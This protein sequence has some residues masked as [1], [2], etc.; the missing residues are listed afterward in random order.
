MTSPPDIAAQMKA[1]RRVLGVMDHHTV[2]DDV[3]SPLHREGLRAVPATL[4]QHERDDIRIKQL[5]DEC[6]RFMR[7]VVL[8]REQHERLEAALRKIASLDKN[9]GA[10]L[11]TRAASEIAR[12]ALDA[13]PP[14]PQGDRT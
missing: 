8:L 3:I 9:S 10:S 11:R 4:Q 14:S 6:Q 5:D 12:A 2:F 7:E 13:A 1:V